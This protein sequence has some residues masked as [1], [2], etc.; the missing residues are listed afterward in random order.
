MASQIRT[1]VNWEA[2]GA[3]IRDRRKRMGLTQPDV[4]VLSGVSQPDL[5]NLEAAKKHAT[6]ETLARIGDVLEV[7]LLTIV[8]KGVAEDAMA[9][10]KIPGPL[11]RYHSR[12]HIL[13]DTDGRGTVPQ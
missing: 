12:S 11:L 13:A 5:S 1:I 9:T 2:I 10:E 6:L 4:A 8:S 7:S 3:Y